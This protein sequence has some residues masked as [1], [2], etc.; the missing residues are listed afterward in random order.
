[1]IN[2]D[3]EDDGEALKAVKWHADAWA[4]ECAWNASTTPLEAFNRRLGA[5]LFGESGDHFGQAIQGLTRAHR[6]PAMKNM[7][8]SR[9]WEPDFAP[10]ARPAVVGSVASNVLAVVRPA[11]EHLQ[12]CQREAVCNQHI[13]EVF[14]FGAQRMELI[15]QR[16]LDGLET[17]QHYA[18]ATRSTAPAAELEQAEQLVRKNRDAHEK[19]GRQF[20]RLWL[21]ESKPYA[22]DWTL[23]RYTNTVKAFDTRLRQ[24]SDARSAAASGQPL[25]T[26][27][28]VG[29]ALPEPLFRRLKPQ[30]VLTIPWSPELPWAEPTATH[31]IGLTIGAGDADR[32]DL[33]VEWEMSAP[34]ELAA[35]PVRAF[36]VS[37]GQVLKEVPAQMEPPD[38]RG[39]Y[40]CVLV[41]PGPLAKGTEASVH[42]YLGLGQAPTG[43]PGTVST[44][45]ATNGSQWLENDQVRL[46]LSPE[47]AHLYRWEIKQAANRDLTMPGET[48]WAGFGDI[49][50]RRSTPYQLECKARGPAMVE[51]ECTDPWGYSELI[52]LYAGASWVETMLSEP[53]SLFWNFDNPA[54][55]AAD[56]PTPG[57]WLFS[58]GQSGAVGR[59]ADGVPAQVKA[60]PVYWSVKFN[61]G[62]MALGLVTPETAAAHVIAPG[63]GA[64]GVGIE[65][66]PAVRH[67]VTFAGLLTA[68]PAETLNRLRQTLALDH[69]IQIRLHGLQPR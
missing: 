46:L 22:L 3:W 52:R 67:L 15:G 20:A 50:P 56:G 11:L 1:M 26:P 63:A 12:A 4:A 44:T 43:L 27:E 30:E 10:L 42:L 37:Q 61:P 9:F 48:G 2:T 55:F 49:N 34:P 69:P 14:Q 59:Q 29:L 24:L 28:A 40:R 19:L 45:P 66:S 7:F 18:Q 32:F 36:Q 62:Q 23:Q 41:L 6:L 25:P 17:A 38:S 35:K 64:G 47:G 58:D 5:V 57:T 60:S 65:N 51:Y 21:A 39:K 8:N 13:L 33:P 53:T 16:M 31:R 54:N 68:P